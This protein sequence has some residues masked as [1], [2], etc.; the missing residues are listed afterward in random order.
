M[1]HLNL[2]VLVLFSASPAQSFFNLNGLGEVTQP[3]D[4]RTIAI[5]NPLALTIAN[6]GNFIELSRTTIKTSVLG[7]GII[8]HQHGNKRAQAT[9]RPGA[10]YTALP[11]FNRSRILFSVDS[12]FNQDF[13]VWSESIAD[14]TTR[15]HIVNRGGVY[16]LNIGIAQ[17]ILNHIC[18]GAQFQ[19][20]LGGTRENWHY[21][22]EGIVATDTIE[23]DYTGRSFRLGSA[24][25][26]SI[27]TLGATWDL[28]FNL[29]AV[30]YKH[31]HGVATDSLT[32]YHLHLPST[33]NFG[34][35]ARP[36]AK[37]TINAGL[38]IRNWANTTINHNPSGY[39]NTWRGAVGIEYDFFPGYP[40]RFGYSKSRWYYNTVAG[41][42]ISESGIC[43]GAGIPLPKFGALDIAAE[44][45]FRNG[46]T[47]GGW[48]GETAGRLNI[49]LAYEEYWAKR[50]RRWGY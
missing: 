3:Q 37:A 40:V 11:V 4:A 32:T 49:T 41:Q 28:P 31:L 23:I 35:S 26:F 2:L 8:A 17:S 24:V 15:Y 27:L 13:D 25:R 10:L 50:T 21:W 44:L 43:L 7:T 1:K 42:P 34:I 47:P 6:P 46:R 19:Q 29:T 5:G 36:N 14:T 16:A 38:E 22:A 9:V 39:Q 45:L 33:L 48:L 12:R 18:L 30:S 20:L